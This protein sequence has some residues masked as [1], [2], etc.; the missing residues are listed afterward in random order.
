MRYSHVY[1]AAIGVLH[2]ASNGAIFVSVYDGNLMTAIKTCSV[3]MRGGLCLI[4]TYGK[5]IF[6]T[7]DYDRLF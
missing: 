7:A 5:T 3:W 2:S 4:L 6:N 1:T